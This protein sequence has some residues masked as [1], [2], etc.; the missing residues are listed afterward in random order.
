MPRSYRRSKGKGRVNKKRIFSRRKTSI[1]KWGQKWG[2]KW[3]G[4]GDCKSMTGGNYPAA[5]VIPINNYNMDPNNANAMIPSRLLPNF[6]GGKRKSKRNKSMH[7]KSMKGGGSFSDIFLGNNASSNLPLTF[8]AS[9]AA[10][11]STN[12]LTG[13]PFLNSSTM[14]QPTGNMFSGSNPP[15]V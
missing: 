6:N 1:Q 5:N 12:I 7:N 3:G 4:C 8:G 15:L 10:S 14:F 13:T 11:L 9:S 2:K